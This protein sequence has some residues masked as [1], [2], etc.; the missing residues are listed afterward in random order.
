MN[1]IRTI[2]KYNLKPD[3]LPF[4]FPLILCL[5]PNFQ[6]EGDLKGPQLLE[7]LMGKRGWPFSGGGCNFNKKDQLKP[8]IFNDKKSLQ[9]KIFFSVIT[10]SSNWEIFTE[11]LVTFKS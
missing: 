1:K 5:Q 10:K 7:G 8:E 11:N 2:S 6:K 3:L 4:N 9:T